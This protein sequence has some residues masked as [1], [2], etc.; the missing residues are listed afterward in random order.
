MENPIKQGE[1]LF[2]EGKIE[3]AEKC[4]LDLLENDPMNAETLNNLGVIQHAKG[5]VK[6]AEDLFLKAIAAKEEYLDALL[7]LAD[8]YQNT[9]RWKEACIHL[10]KCI[11]IENTDP[12]LFN[13]LGT[14]YLEMAETEKARVT[15]KKSLE[16]NPD[17][18]IVADSLRALEKKGS[19]PRIAISEKP[20]NILFVQEAPCIRNYKM[21]T[22]LRSRGHRISLAY[23]KARLSQMYK[24]LS[25]DVYDENIHISNFRQL[26]DI[27]RHYDIVHCHNEP[28]I[29]TVA[30][31]AGEAPVIHDTHDLISLRA[32]G[33]LNLSYFEGVANR[34]ATGRVYTTPYQMEEA[35]KLYGVN[36]PSLVLYNYVSESDLPKNSL[37]KL[38]ARDG[39]V[40]IVYEGGIGGN[41]HRD[42]FSLF[43]QLAKLGNHIHIYP[44]FYDTEIAR[45]FSEFPNIHYSNP[46]S[47]KQ[48]IEAMSQ[49]D[50]GIIPFNLEKG[51]KRFLDS[52]IANKLFEYLAAGLPVLASPL[53]SYIEYFSTN[54]VGI[55]FQNKEDITKN[56]SRLKE[57]A[58]ITD[59][60]RQVFTYEKE[61]ARLEQFYRQVMNRGSRIEGIGVRESLDMGSRCVPCRICGSMHTER[62]K[63]IYDFHVI[64]CRDCE[65]RFVHPVPT[66]EFSKQWYSEQ[67]KK[68]RWNNDLNLAIEA[69]HKQNKQTYETY[70]A[71]ISENTELRGGEKVL[72]VGC[73]D[74]LFLKK[75]ADIGYECKGIDL[76]RY[77]IEYGRQ[78]YGLDLECGTIFDF[79]FPEETFD[80]VIFNQLLE[81][82]PDPIR[83]LV[84][85]RRI[86][87]NNGVVFLSVPNCGA[88]IYHIEQRF[89]DDSIGTRFLEVPNHLYYFSKKSLELA[90]H[91]AGFEIR[92]HKSYETRKTSRDFLEKSGATASSLKKLKAELSKDGISKNAKIEEYFDRAVLK[93]IHEETALFA[94][95]TDNLLGQMVIAR[96]TAREVFKTEDEDRH[97][98][99]IKKDRIFAPSIKDI[100][101]F[102]SQYWDKTEALKHHGLLL[103]NLIKQA[104][105]HVPFW[106]KE[107]RYR[108][109][110]PKDIQAFEDLEK[111]PVVDKMVMRKQIRDFIADNADQFGFYHG[112][113]GGSTGRPFNYLI[114]KE[115]AESID[116]TQRRG[117]RWAGWKENSRLLTVA[118]GGLGPQGGKKIE[119]FGFTDE[120][121]LRVYQEILTYNPEFYRGLP[122][123]MDLF[124]SYL[125]KLEL[126]ENI[127]G[128]ASFLTSEVLLDSQRQ[129]ISKHLGEVFDTY[130][131]N[132]GG[133]NAM[134][135]ENHDGFHISHEIFLLELLS[136]ENQRV[137]SNQ[138]G[139]I[140][141]THLYNLVMPWIRYKSDDLARVT[142]D[143]CA[144]G[145]TLPLIRD[146]KGRVTDYLT[147]PNAIIN[148]TELCNMINH[149]PMRAYQFIQNEEKSILVKIVKEIG[150]SKNDE[151][152][153]HSK[154][155]EVDDNVSINFQYV[156]DIPLTKGGKFK[157]VTN[158]T[159]RKKTHPSRAEAK[160]KDKPKICHIG[161]AHSVHV[162]DIIEELDKRGYEQCVISYYPPETA[163]TPK[164][165]PV[166]YFPYR[167]YE[168]PDWQRLKLEGRL[169]E[170]LKTAFEK[171]APDIVHG[172]SLTYSC[173]PVW[174]AKIRFGIR[175]VLVPWSSQTMKYP[176]GVANHY[177]KRCIETLDYFLHGMP[178]VFKRYQSYYGNL[179]AE[180]YVFFRPLIDLSLYDQIRKISDTPKILSAR[181]MGEFYCQDL[182][183]KAIPYL[184]NKFPATKATFII[185][186]NPNQGREYFERMIQMAKALG[187]AQYC[188]FIPHS[189]SQAEFAELIKSHNIVYSLAVHDEGFSGTTLQAAY[190][191]A[192][193]IVQDTSDID[194]ILDHKL[195]VLR[196]KIDGK[197]VRET[198]LHAA[199]NLKSLQKRFARENRERLYAY[200]KEN[201]IKNLTECYGKISLH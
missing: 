132:D 129:R 126:N 174:M 38:S 165:I 71:T 16:L 196:T 130:G 90:I 2:A 63:K 107:M 155:K 35:Q 95:T 6:G 123:L 86:L 101:L 192:V 133:S 146:L 112:N 93:K 124:C 91:K 156:Q 58:E 77:F 193:T 102:E 148:G 41:G 46:L 27:S 199:G 55:T 104:Y 83:F 3:E 26:W 8:L 138:E 178:N 103:E 19:A 183:V 45:Y 154:I 24:G 198:L 88:L 144:C 194:G 114:S 57:I 36:G 168:S 157:Y 48:I 69:N 186:Q 61:I 34:G 37:P 30:A 149:L 31:L 185:G 81:H 160:I 200:G 75:F 25:D 80:I 164:H 189:L 111:L 151:D 53:R 108:G 177:E 39:K 181:V 43:V 23:T 89:L 141:C 134:E 14:I 76:N 113:T 142:H 158:D 68:K 59:F 110:K 85:V 120:T 197:S 152:Y 13:Q 4:F 7:N 67:E 18:Q 159:G 127:K 153:I 74:G 167:G 84:E 96:K 190:S 106:K 117:W 54:P 163:I 143:R 116:C 29:L 5:N 201:M 166:Y 62:I 98:N 87:K 137:D 72:E 169:E 145:R 147:T 176:N 64:F 82:L 32:N 79:N 49:F 150:F 188:D 195:N 94:S 1:A 182:L 22:A 128:K 92:L 42:F 121:A 119:M 140:T 33:D 122:Y 180:K 28:D 9:K 125:E 175:S 170:F 40:H 135:C 21:A 173:I 162:S 51:N 172:H 66:E 44:T 171:E 73:F 131:V 10:E 136:E 50:F 97:F 20:L 118:G 15:L 109:L 179:P 99:V 115:Q 161:G 52:T 11:E 56:V 60:S 105:Y 17:Q 187:V 70:F 47:P 139:I 78:K 191:G 65:L 184:V 12:N 100:D